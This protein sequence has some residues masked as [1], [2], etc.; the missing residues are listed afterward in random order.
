MEQDSQTAPPAARTKNSGSNLLLGIGLS[1]VL[2]AG[3][4]FS[5]MQ[6]GTGQ[7]LSE[8]LEASA[9]S[10]F[11]SQAEPATDV[12]FGEF[13]RVWNLMEEKFVSSTS[14][15]ALTSEDMLRGAIEGL[16]DSYGDPYSVYLPPREAEQFEENISGNFSGVGMEVGMRNAV[17]TVIAPLPDTPA[18]KAGI[19]P[20]DAIIRIDEVSTEGMNIDEAV[21]RI[22][23]E[24]GTEVVLTVYREGEVEL[25]EIPVIRDTINI[26]TIDTELQG[27]VFIISLYSFNAL[28][29]M[30]MQEALREYVT[31]GANKLVLDLRGN[32]GGFLQSAVSISSYFLP[33]G[34][35][36]VREN[37]GDDTAEQVFRSQGKTLQEFAPEDI[38]ILIDRGSAS[39]SEIMAGALSQHGVATLIGATTF[40]KG[41]VQELVELPEGSSLKVTI[42]RWLTPDGTSISAGGLTP[43][44]SIPRTAA[45]I[46]SETDP[47]LEAALEWLAGGQD[48]AAL[49]AKYAAT[50]TEETT[51]E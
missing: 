43:D 37:F 46:M 31:S 21:K 20:G 28:A 41:S 32:P 45:D 36:I 4:F 18:E 44:V 40:G 23:G 27:D 15:G 12:D 19:M 6:I 38:V 26:P 48:V 8:G 2:A 10:F 16:V 11:Q 47:Q 13:W 3:A 9:Y 5:G 42:A 29:E 25:L 17:V 34:K 1:L 50:S 14:T 35:V 39:A 49:E 22:R 24:K 30:K 51:T 7:S 33:T